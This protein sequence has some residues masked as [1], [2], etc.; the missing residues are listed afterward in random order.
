VARTPDA[1]T[2]LAV[3]PTTLSARQ[4]Q[5]ER[6][7]SFGETRAREERENVMFAFQFSKLEDAERCFDTLQPWLDA[8]RGNANNKHASLRVMLGISAHPA[9]HPSDP[10]PAP[11]DLEPPRVSAEAA[12]EE[13]MTTTEVMAMME[14]VSVSVNVSGESGESGESVH[15]R[16]AIGNIDASLDPVRPID[17]EPGPGVPK[18]AEVAG[19]PSKKNRDEFP[20]KSEKETQ[21]TSAPL[22]PWSWSSGLPSDIP[23]EAAREHVGELLR[24]CLA[25]E[26]SQGVAS[27]AGGADGG[28]AAFARAPLGFGMPLD[29]YA[30]LV[31]EAMDEMIRTGEIFVPSDQHSS[32][33]DE[34]DLDEDPEDERD[35][36][37]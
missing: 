11:E 8:P 9:A 23:D 3:G 16:N 6:L 18:S 30:R 28:A 19:E 15:E 33:D 14:T 29:R 2:L 1:N 4:R 36:Y 10:N 5:N 20:G 21:T 24:V 37:F 26:G 31:G 27:S 13:L 32:D 7:I 25:S 22:E 35:E 12:T 17:R 34:T